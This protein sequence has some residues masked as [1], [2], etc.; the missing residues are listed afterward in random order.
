[1]MD[2]IIG[3]GKK[4][5][6]VV[7]PVQ[8][9]TF[10]EK[11]K[12]TL[13]ILITYYILGS[14]TVWGIDPSAV[15]QFE[16]LEIVFGSKFGSLITLGIGPIVT[17][18][19]ILQLLVGAKIIDWNL[20]DPEDKAKYTS[21]QK[22]LGITFAIVEAIAYVMFGA[23]PP[24]SGAAVVL[25]AVILQL[26][27]GG[28]L[29]M[30]MDE[31]VSK[32][33][34]GSGISLFIAAGVSKTIFL[35][36]FSPPLGEAGGGIIA[37]FLGSLA[38]G[39][40]S[41]A[42]ISL[43]PLISTIVVFSIVVFASSI[44]VEIPMAFALPFGKFA[45]RKWPLKF[46]YTSNIPVIL[47]MA[48]L[49]NAKAAGKMLADRG[50]EFLGTYDS[51]GQVVSGLLYYLTPPTSIGAVFVS[52][53]AGVFA[54]IIGFAAHRFIKKYVLRMTFI[55]GLIGIVIAVLL[56]HA[57]ALPQMTTEEIGRALIYII[58]LIIGSVVF[59]FFW[60]ST[61]GMDAHSISQQFKSSSIMIP[62]FRHDSRIVERVLQRY[63]PALTV[64]G[65]AFVGLL[66]GFADLTSA[67]GTGTGILL[68]VMIVHQMY[69]QIMQQHADDLPEVVKRFI[70]GE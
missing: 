51:Q 57:L 54:I 56:L 48:V 44:R 30:L 15:A 42:F 23:I 68:T 35:R 19:I 34:I 26:A 45:S 14:I 67:L 66:A 28:I 69:E 70:G 16:F 39:Q 46:I 18:S 11:I 55:G 10:S 22:V 53:F 61:S 63:I 20:Q 5:P 17:A 64:L 65:G 62:G 43:L 9:L 3:I 38:Q 13:L 7:A 37:V 21:T 1:M 41:T 52:V 58:V 60:T 36:I 59:A 47:T 50:I 33:G 24:A 8:K 4:F 12:W 31:V 29:I 25:V 40:P 49:A 6:S 27:F 2:A 32:W